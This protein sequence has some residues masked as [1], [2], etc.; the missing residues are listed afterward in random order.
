MLFPVH[1]V[2]FYIF[3]VILIASAAMVITAKDPVKSVLFL[4][5]SFFAS[6]VL[7]MLM[8]AEFLSLVLI[9]VYVGA[10]M[11]LFLFVVMMLNIDQADL[12]TGF[13]KYAPLGLITL[14]I[15]VG[16]AFYA[17]SSMHWDAANTLPTHYASDYNSTKEIGMLLF[18]QY[19]FPFELAAVLLLVGM[20]SAIALAFHG[21]KPDAK[22]QKIS[23][24]LKATKK[25]NLKI[26]NMDDK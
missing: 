2:I 16:T 1:Q 12:K 25:N 17:M 6:S 21:R 18:T 15:L 13:I 19:L 7:W 24:Q 14:I 8:Q 4:V 5:A 20:I 11:T 22:S 26:I 9:F 23:E 3:T 10:V